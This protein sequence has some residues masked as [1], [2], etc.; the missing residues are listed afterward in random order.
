MIDKKY[1]WVHDHVHVQ[2]HTQLTC[3]CSATISTKEVIL[4]NKVLKR[5]FGL[6]FYDFLRMFKAYINIQCRLL[7]D[8]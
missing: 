5:R 3:I 6:M 1:T 4:V 2:V 7:S 8:S